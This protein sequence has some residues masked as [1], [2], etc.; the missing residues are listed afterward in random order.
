MYGNNLLLL[1]DVNCRHM[2][3]LK[4]VSLQLNSLSASIHHGDPNPNLATSY[5]VVNAYIW[6]PSPKDFADPR[7]SSDLLSASRTSRNQNG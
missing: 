6:I 3:K 1:A 4:R 7:T 5:S 2:F